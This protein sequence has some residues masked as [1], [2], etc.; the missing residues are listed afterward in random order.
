MTIKEKEIEI[1]LARRCFLRRATTAVGGIGLVA[2]AVPFVEYWL[3]SVDTEAAAAPVTVDISAL[4]PKQQLTV[5][6]RGQPVW[7]IRR[8]QEMIDDLPKLNEQLRDPSSLEDQQPD[9]A[10][11]V[12][13]SI[14]PD[15]FIAIGVCTHL[16]C[17]PTYRPDIGGISLDWLGGFYCPCHGSRYDLAGRVYKA[18]PAPL[19]LKIPRYMYTSDKEIIVGK[20]QYGVEGS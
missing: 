14:K 13:R 4:Q 12:Y 10:K 17:I 7:I 20:D 8:T 3:P 9:Y 18:V 5:S 11:N 19:N 2:T 15:Y 16:G 6:W 1:D